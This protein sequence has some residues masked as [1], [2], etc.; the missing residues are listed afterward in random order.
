MNLP[1]IFVIPEVKQATARSKTWLHLGR[2]DRTGL[3]MLCTTNGAK[4]HRQGSLF[5]V[6]GFNGESTTLKKFQMLFWDILA[7]PWS[8]SRELIEEW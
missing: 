7:A 8:V 3:S 5:L 6:V 4:L 2:L 1:P